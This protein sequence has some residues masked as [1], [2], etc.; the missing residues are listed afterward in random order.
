MPINEENLLRH[1]LIGLRVKVI[2]SSNPTLIEKEGVIMDETK[3]TLTIQEQGE[4]KNIPKRDVSLSITLPK[5]EKVK[6]DGRKLIVRPE[7]RTK[8][9]R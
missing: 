8:K 7:D 2:E 9:I 4:L 1:E 5:G 6:V 3:K